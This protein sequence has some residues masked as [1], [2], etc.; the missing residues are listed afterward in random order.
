MSRRFFGGTFLG[1]EKGCYYSHSLLRSCADNLGEIKIN[2][3]FMQE[4]TKELVFW[5][6]GLLYIAIVVVK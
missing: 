3:D 1:A 4:N 2:T 6:K 5:E